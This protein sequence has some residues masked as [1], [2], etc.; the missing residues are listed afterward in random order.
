M[1]Y[2]R[3]I[4]DELKVLEDLENIQSKVKQVELVE[5][6]CKQWFRYNMKKNYLNR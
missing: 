4:K 1:I 5:T 3:K 6:L 2:S